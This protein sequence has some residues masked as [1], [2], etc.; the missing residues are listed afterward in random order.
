MAKDKER[1]VN[2]AQ[3]QRKL[4]K[5]KALKKGKAEVQARRNEKLA[6]RNPE[7]LQRQVD[8]L[9]AL[10]ESGQ[11]KPREKQ[12]L[13]QLQKDVN[14]IRKAREVLGDKA[15][16]FGSAQTTSTKPP[17]PQGSYGGRD[18]SVLG[19][20]GR[21]GERKQ[22]WHDNGYQ[23]S[24]S[25]TD[26]SVRRIPMPKDTPPPIPQQARRNQGRH[27]TGANMEPLGG[28]RSPHGLP[29][30]PAFAPQA[31]TTY[32]SAPQLRDLKKEAVARFVPS[33][34][35]KKLEVVKG[36]GG[37]VEPEELDRLE[38]AGYVHGVSTTNQIESR[39]EANSNP[40]PPSTVLDAA[41]EAK[42]LAEEEKQFQREL[43]Q[44]QIE[45]VSDEDR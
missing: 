40:K 17:R 13:E 7:R 23:S 10:E 2:P 19:K 41:T 11:I 45:E 38:K 30:K 4:E 9:K 16:Q 26:D 3:Q 8:D 29:P 12:L 28:G 37:L 21:D 39:V 20:H 18:G 34:V 27:G 44:V 1:S 14:A 22:A 31:K 25:E 33:V 32:E 35:R 36:S 6:R 42:K 24:G 5:A 43:R 15:P